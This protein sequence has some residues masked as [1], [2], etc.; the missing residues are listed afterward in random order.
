MAKSLL[1]FMGP[2]SFKQHPTSGF[3]HPAQSSVSRKLIKGAGETLSSRSV[4][5]KMAANIKLTAHH[6]QVRSLRYVT[7]VRTAEQLIFES[8]GKQRYQG[9][10]KLGFTGTKAGQIPG[11]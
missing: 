9:F 2:G 3:E 4:A 8:V 5:R 7:P 1:G 6:S 11:P 10:M